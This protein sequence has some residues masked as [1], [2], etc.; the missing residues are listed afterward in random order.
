MAEVRPHFTLTSGKKKRHRYIFNIAKLYSFFL[1]PYLNSN[2]FSALHLE[3][4]DII[5]IH[6]LMLINCLFKKI[7]INLYSCYL[8][9]PLH[10]WDLIN[11]IMGT[12]KNGLESD[13]YFPYQSFSHIVY[14]VL[15]AYSFYNLYYW[16]HYDQ[17][18]VNMVISY[19]MHT[20]KLYIIKKNIAYLLV[21]VIADSKY[22]DNSKRVFLF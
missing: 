6:D 3:H 18:T 19:Y 8:S 5:L 21:C 1:L 11:Y 2:P 7:S 20:W 17:C 13:Q 10:L 15:Y 22:T 9:I 16:H 4:G 12:L 14:K